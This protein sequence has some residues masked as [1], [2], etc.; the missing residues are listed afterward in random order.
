LPISVL[1]PIA[2]IF[3]KTYFL[4]SALPSNRSQTTGIYCR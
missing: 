2:E 4:I 3:R 1:A